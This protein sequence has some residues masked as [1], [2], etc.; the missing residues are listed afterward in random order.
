[1]PCTA[2]GAGSA[3]PHGLSR[4]AVHF[5]MRKPRF[6]L[7]DGARIFFLMIGFWIRIAGRGRPHRPPPA[8]SEK[9]RGTAVNCYNYFFS[10]ITGLGSDNIKSFLI[11]SSRLTGGITTGF[12]TVPSVFAWI[13]PRIVPTEIEPI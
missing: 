12:K 6:V 2:L 5:K 7:A 9:V 8:Y 10:S 3:C 11:I 4:R 13:T 1:M